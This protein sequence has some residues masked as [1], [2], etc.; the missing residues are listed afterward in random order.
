VSATSACQSCH[1]WKLLLLLLATVHVE[2]CM[3]TCVRYLGTS[4]CSILKLL[5]CSCYCCWLQE[6]AAI[7]VQKDASEAKYKHALV[8]GRQEQVGQKQLTTACR[9]LGPLYGT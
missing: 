5:C 4:D 3:H 6:K 9:T 2:W 1:W 7:K 8:D